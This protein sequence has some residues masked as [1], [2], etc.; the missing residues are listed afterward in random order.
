MGAHLR[1][2]CVGH[3][4]AEDSNL[5]ASENDGQYGYNLRYYGMS[6]FRSD[7]D[8]IQEIIGH[9]LGVQVCFEI[10]RV[11]VIHSTSIRVANQQTR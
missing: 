3:I 4:I 7:T 2:Y 10:L 8:L 1:G 5:S 11:I 9:A 6:L